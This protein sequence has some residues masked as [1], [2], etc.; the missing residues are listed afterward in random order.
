MRTETN[1]L[2]L[3]ILMNINVKYVEVK[4]TKINSQHLR[5]EYNRIVIILREKKNVYRKWNQSNNY[6]RDALES[7]KRQVGTL[8]IWKP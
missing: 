6:I 2:L 4:Y 1:K 8:K 5:V 7:L 3:V